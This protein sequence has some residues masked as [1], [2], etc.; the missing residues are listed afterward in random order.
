M[1]PSAQSHGRSHSLLLVQKL[2]NLRDNSSPLTLVIDS[3]K[4]TAAP[5]MREFTGRA[6]VSSASR[7]VFYPPAP[8][9]DACQVSPTGET[10]PRRWLNISGPVPI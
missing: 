4:Q 2:L 5:L 9:I 1:A 8:P 10:V 7:S 6:Q 3:L